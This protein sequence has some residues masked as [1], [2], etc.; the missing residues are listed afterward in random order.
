MRQSGPSQELL[1]LKLWRSIYGWTVLFV[2]V[3]FLV[4]VAVASYIGGDAVN[5]K[6]EGGHYYLFGY[7]H[8]LG[9]KGYT[10]VTPGVFNYSKWHSYVVMASWL[11]MPGVGRLTWSSKPETF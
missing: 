2:I 9:A 11:L 8:G 7:I 4:Y 1:K 10:E 5:G 3:N 6:V